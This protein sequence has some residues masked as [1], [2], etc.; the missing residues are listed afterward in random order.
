MG[1]GVCDSAIIDKMMV[2]LKQ[3]FN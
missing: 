3:Q 2:V 1:N